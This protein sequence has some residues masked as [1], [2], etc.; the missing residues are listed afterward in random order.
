[1]K[2]TTKRTTFVALLLALALVLALVP[3]SGFT[4]PATNDTVINP[5]HVG[6]IT[7][8]KYKL[9]GDSPSDYPDW[10]NDGRED[11]TQVPSSATPLA[12][13][14][15]Y[16]QKVTT[17]TAG[18]PDVVFVLN[19]GASDVYYKPD[20][21]WARA[22]QNGGLGQ[23]I[24]TN[25]NG[26]ASTGSPDD[27]PVGIYLVSEKPG[28]VAT[29]ADPFL[30]YI[31]TTI[32]GSVD[33]GTTAGLDESL[34][35]LLYDVHAYPK[36]EDLE[37]HKQVGSGVD[38]DTA[39]A[40][41]QEE[42]TDARG[43]DYAEPVNWYLSAEIPARIADNG[44]RYSIVDTYSAGLLLD[45]NSISIYT[46]SYVDRTGTLNAGITLAYGTDYTYTVTGNTT[47]AGGGVL[48]IVL[49]DAGRARLGYDDPDNSGNDTGDYNYFKLLHVKLTTTV[50]E[51]AALNVP[52]P[53]ESKL[54]F[55]NTSEYNGSDSS[56]PDDPEDTPPG[57]TPPPVIERPSEIPYIYTGGFR[58]L[59][60]DTQET[61][62]LVGAKFK[63]IKVDPK[64]TYYNTAANWTG[65]AVN[66]GNL[67]F[68][69]AQYQADLAAATARNVTVLGAN[70]PYEQRLV[71]GS[72]ADYEVTTGSGGTASFTGLSY[73]LQDADPAEDEKTATPA[74][75]YLIE[76]DAPAGYR[77]PDVN[78]TPIVKVDYTSYTQN[79][80][81]G[82]S[83]TP[84]NP[85]KIYNSKAFLL[86]FTGGEGSLYFVI[87]G[88]V[89]VLLGVGILVGTR[90][91]KGAQA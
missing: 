80:A 84:S 15:F 24:V 65:G 31:P 74:Y 62:Q 55:C 78:A 4:S 42:L 7:I 2:R 86:P 72:Y 37:M 91:K 67:K 18:D 34:D 41:L 29:P 71:T 44:S 36:N 13:I 69:Y 9:K 6:S 85:Y 25:S 51:S 63:L 56:Y 43:A 77:L 40:G 49:T 79:T 39:T 82:V 26:E 32:Q 22:S 14:T 59:K 58:I 76:T 64:S 27:L 12:N 89:I 21:T 87:G 90:R 35:Y 57:P 75:Y 10:R 83:T 19:G 46:D 38:T 11:D 60:Q 17:T 81:T 66:S 23:S 33:D 54:Q 16:V 70:S 50:L 73:G 88:V 20:T 3:A 53:N 68:D 61:T 5:A 48:K 1:M 28:A 30:V 8:H 52:I 45:T 47:P